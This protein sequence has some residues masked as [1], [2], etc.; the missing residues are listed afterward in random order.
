MVKSDETLFKL[1]KITSLITQLQQQQKEMEERL[2]T[3]IDIVDNKFAPLNLRFNTLDRKIDTLD[4][5]IEAV[6][7]KIDSSQKDTIDTLTELIHT[8]HNMNEKRFKRLEEHAKIA[9]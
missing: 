2:N 3:K 1:D 9:S 6:N 5:K 8:G 4:L 7:Q